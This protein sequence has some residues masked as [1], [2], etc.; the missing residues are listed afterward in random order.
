[1]ESLQQADKEL[2]IQWIMD[3]LRRTLVHYGYWFREVEHQFGPEIAH[4]M[5]RKAGDSHQVKDSGKSS[6][7]R[8]YDFRFLPP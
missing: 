6:Q 8:W 4:E 7:S 2:L 3:A 1:M 5:E